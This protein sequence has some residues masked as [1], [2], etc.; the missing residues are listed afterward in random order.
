MKL[1]FKLSFT[2]SFTTDD[3]FAI[4]DLILHSRIIIFHG[5]PKTAAN[6]C[7]FGKG[8]TDCDCDAMVAMVM[9]KRDE[10]GCSVHSFLSLHTPCVDVGSRRAR[11]D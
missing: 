6:L 10:E 11:V 2:Y 7:L 9:M 8:A 1:F 4:P 3:N 5:G